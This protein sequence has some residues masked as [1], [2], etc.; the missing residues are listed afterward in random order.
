[1][2]HAGLIVDNPVSGERFVFRTTAEDTGGEL[3]AFE[4]EV[5]PGGRVPGGHVHPAQEER[6][7]VTSGT[8]RFKK[9]LRWVTAESGDE[10]IVPAGTSHR[11]ANVGE[12][13]AKVLVQV[14]PALRMQELFEAVASLAGEGR[15]FQ[16]GMPKPLDLALFMRE[17]EPEVRA[18]VAPG[19]VRAVMSPLVWIARRRGLQARYRAVPDRAARTTTPT[20]PASPGTPGG[21]AWAAHVP[22]PHVR[23]RRA[24]HERRRGES[25]R[26]SRV[27]QSGAPLRL[28]LRSERE[29]SI[30]GR[31]RRAMRSERSNRPHG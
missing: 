29:R 28:P 6:F 30:R 19:I 4:L 3:L 12:R 25:A 10:V 27:S 15:T 21:D 7:E 16:S 13:P 26:A 23:G 5:P 9:G 2:A 18:P 20:H 17:F 22:R 14:R 8:M 24:R 31:G 1:M 11:F